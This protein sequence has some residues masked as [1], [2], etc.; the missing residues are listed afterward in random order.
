MISTAWA[1]PN[2][3]G[4]MLPPLG[5]GPIPEDLQRIGGRKILDK[6]FFVEP[7]A[8]P[9]PFSIVYSKVE[10]RSNLFQMPLGR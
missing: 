10:A 5:D 6:D 1:I 4:A 7:V 8:L 9:T 3:R 2:P